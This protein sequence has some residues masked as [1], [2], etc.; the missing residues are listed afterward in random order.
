[1]EGKLA[2]TRGGTPHLGERIDDSNRKQ[3]GESMNPDSAVFDESC[4]QRYNF[5]ELCTID[6]ISRSEWNDLV[7]RGL[8]MSRSLFRRREL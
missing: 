7:V 4:F 6:G 1:M 8:L 5:V 2:S 3:A